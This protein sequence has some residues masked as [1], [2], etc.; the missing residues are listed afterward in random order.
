MGRALKR[1]SPRIVQYVNRN[2][3]GLAMKELIRVVQSL[4]P[5]FEPNDRGRP[6]K[7]PRLV[8]FAVMWKILFCHSYD[9]VE[10][11]LKMHEEK[12]DDFHVKD[13]ELRIRM[14]ELYAGH[15]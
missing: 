11:A 5:P 1:A 13:Q 12:L 15:P 7:D 2:F 4:P 6:C 8:A 10:S 14:P 3:E 9:S